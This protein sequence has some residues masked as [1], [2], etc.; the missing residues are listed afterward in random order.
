MRVKAAATVTA[1][2]F[3]IALWIPATAAADDIVWNPFLFIPYCSTCGPL[4]PLTT[5]QADARDILPAGVLSGVPPISDP[6][7]IDD[8]VVSIPVPPPPVDAGGSSNGG[9]PPVQIPSSDGN[10]NNG[11]GNRGGGNGGGGNGSGGN[12]GG[13]NSGGSGGIGGAGNDGGAGTLGGGPPEFVFGGDPV[14]GF[15]DGPINGINPPIN[16][17][18]DVGRDLETPAVVPEP[19]TL[20]LLGSGLSAA[21]LR[22]RRAK[23]IEK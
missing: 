8:G 12:S 13:G 6:G 15:G 20:L 19:T 10:G 5:E 23:R 14:G 16:D 3:G 17:G 18:Y 22:R 21:A 11:G 7:P 9:A 2:V 1:A 4:V